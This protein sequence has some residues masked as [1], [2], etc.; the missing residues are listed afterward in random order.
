MSTEKHTSQA[1][2]IWLQQQNQIQT[3]PEVRAQLLTQYRDDGESL[4]GFVLDDQDPLFCKY[5]AYKKAYLKVA[6]KAYEADVNHAQTENRLP[7]SLDY[8]IIE[9]FRNSDPI[10]ELGVETAERVLGKY[11][12][13]GHA[14]QIIGRILEEV[15]QAAANFIPAH[16]P[17]PREK[18]TNESTGHRGLPWFGYIEFVT[19][20]LLDGIN[21]DPAVEASRDLW[22][23]SLIWLREYVDE[24]KKLF[25]DGA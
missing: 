17:D 4:A 24:D 15:K 2:E 10:Q 16:S 20:R 5:T 13:D 22:K 19:L 1:Y 18:Y 25:N 21:D 23:P 12:D 14:P 7:R 3:A 8:Y 11:L 6:R 9:Q